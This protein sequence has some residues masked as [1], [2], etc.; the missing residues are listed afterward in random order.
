MEK[1]K[2]IGLALNK[3]GFEIYELKEKLKEQIT[4]FSM[5]E[6]ITIYDASYIALAQELNTILYT[7]DRELIAKFPRKTLHI[8]DYV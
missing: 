6:N 4:E 7:A 3:Y 8:K 1:E 5:K 2:I